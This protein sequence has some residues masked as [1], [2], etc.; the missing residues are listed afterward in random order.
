M[1]HASSA[2]A[3]PSRVHDGA[4][5]CPGV[6]RLH[7]AEDGAL[8]RVR[9]PGGRISS[10]Q[11]G[12]I[13]EAARAGNGIVE[14]TSRANLQIR[15]LPAD[16]GE[17]IAAL[18]SGAGLL[19]S[20]GHEL[21]RNV[22]ASP[23][24]GRHPGALAPTDA[25]VSAL[26]DA[27]CDEADLVALPGRFLFAVD[28]GS[29]LT[30]GARA[31][32]LLVARSGGAFALV[33][34]GAAT[35]LGVSPADAAALAVRAARAFLALAAE[36]AARPWRIRD[37]GDGA[38]AVVR[39]L[40]G[41]LLPAPSTGAGALR[42]DPGITG[43]NDGRMALTALPPLARLDPDALAALQVLAV[44]GDGE[45]RLSPWRTLTLRDVAAADADALTRALTA[46]GLVVSAGSGW[47]GLSACAGMG[48]CTKALLDVRAIA[49]TRAAVRDGSSP[50]EH[51]SACERRCGQPQGVEIGVAAA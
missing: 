39:A 22:L 3:R 14:L 43:Q 19:P 11:I 36:S 17:R 37:L 8:A 47:T 1:P 9:L 41:E 29:G 27:L 31:D 18:L 48:A 30:L 15:G 10:A 26:D 38:R 6:L 49:A 50:S 4:D 45:L 40:G 20:R 16:A 13:A 12:A 34:D 21:V 44:R 33:L 25:I 28:D 2:A 5:R 51:W 46:T 24:A 23:L 32:V 35:T 42:L 7:A